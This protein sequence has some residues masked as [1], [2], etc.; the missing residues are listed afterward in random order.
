[1]TA[2]AHPA[3]L[4]LTQGLPPLSRVLMAASMTLAVWDMRA[5]SRRDLAT[6]PGDRL[7]D[8]GLTP[9]A[10]RREAAKPFW[11]E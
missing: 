4:S 5:R 10:A 2:L 9:E 1:M 11:R 8:L 7:Q 3:P 6:L